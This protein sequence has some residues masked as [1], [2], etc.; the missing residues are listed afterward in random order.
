LMPLRT[1][2]FNGQTVE[3][4]TAPGAR[5]NP[6]WLDF[7]HTA[8][9]RSSIRI[10][11]KN[12]QEDEAITLGLRLLDK[13][14]SAYSTS[15]DELPDEQVLRVINEFNYETQ[16]DLLASIGLGNNMPMVMA[17]LLLQHEDEQQGDQDKQEVFAPLAIKGTEGAVVTYAKCCRPIPGDPIIGFV[18][19]GRGIVIHTEDCKNV[20]EYRDKPEKWI[21]VEWEAEVEGEFPIDIKILAISR[22]GTLATVA[23][24]IADMDANIDNVGIEERDGLHST[25]SFTILVKNRKHL[26]R[27]MKRLR[28]L[29][30]VERIHRIKR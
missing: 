15:F 23:A 12:L 10:Y 19:S 25:I 20:A 4:I 1:E 18:S 7:V 17:H 30:M 24:A 8:K 6:A 2:L 13:S 21:D 28:S 3:I 29:E 5:P 26:A 22:R 16:E 27:I 11:L 9:A 14:L